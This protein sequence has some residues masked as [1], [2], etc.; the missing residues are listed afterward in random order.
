MKAVLVEV[1]GGIAEVVRAPKEV[2]VE[3]IDLDSLREGDVEDVRQ[4]WNNSLSASARAYV[5]QRY[6]KIFGHL[7]TEYALTRR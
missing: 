5:K 7:T 6:P 4:Y 1:R 3:I 2:A